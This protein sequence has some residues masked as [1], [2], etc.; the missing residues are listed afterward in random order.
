[1]SASP[2]FAPPA[3]PAP[4]GPA[5][6]RP[7]FAPRSPSGAPA[8]LPP[9]PSPNG[10]GGT[11]PFSVIGSQPLAAAYGSAA[12]DQTDAELSLLTPDELP[13]RPAVRPPT[14]PHR[15]EPPTS[16][17]PASGP[18]AR[19]DDPRLVE[20]TSP[21][22]RRH[23][24]PEPR[25]DSS[26]GRLGA[27]IEFPRSARRNVPEQHLPPR[28]GEQPRRDTEDEPT[29]EYRPPSPRQAQGTTSTPIADGDGDLLIFAQ[30]RSAWFTGDE[31]SP[32][33]GEDWRTE[34]DVGWNAAEAA[35]SPTVG[36][37]TRS[38]LPRRVPSANLVPGTAPQRDRDHVH[39]INRDA[40]QLAAHTAGY[41]R[42]WNR[43]RQ[44]AHEAPDYP[45]VRHQ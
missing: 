3:R 8:A 35:S 17:P 45:S 21:N 36:G 14:A 27:L 25:T 15:S 19:D 9:A 43:A 20:P 22:L 39:P 30:A 1:V 38:G 26:P 4:P 24:Q 18:G 2:V 11:G 32:S 10:G 28:I 42:G 16:G 5:D 23:A 33:V 13:T 12:P 31:E 7:P 44:D 34:A 29:Q 37:T 6:P 41:F 40:A